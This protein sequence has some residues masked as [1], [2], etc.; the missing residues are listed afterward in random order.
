[1]ATVATG[2]CPLDQLLISTCTCG[3]SQ[4]VP[5]SPPGTSYCVSIEGID[6]CR[7]GPKC[8]KTGGLASNTALTGYDMSGIF[9]A[10]PYV[11]CAW[12]ATRGKT[13]AR[14][15]IFAR[16]SDGRGWSWCDLQLF[17]GFD[18]LMF[19][20]DVGVQSPL[21]IGKVLNFEPVAPQT[22]FDVGVVKIEPISTPNGR[23]TGD[24]DD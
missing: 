8:E 3:S 14:T 16:A 18:Q 21:W 7:K 10:V 24:G 2:N 19:Q 15:K 11:A 23:A 6:Q 4:C 9:I 5:P 1:M 13:S 17:A 22:S 20:I 12:F